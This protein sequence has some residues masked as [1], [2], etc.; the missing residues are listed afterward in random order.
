[1]ADDYYQLLGVSRTATLEE[2]KKAYKSRA[3]ECHPDRPTGS[4]QLF[5][6]VSKAHQVL[7]NTESRRQY[8]R[9]LSNSTEAFASRFSRVATAAQDTAK[10][11]ITDFVDEGLF[12]TLESFLQKKHTPKDIKASVTIS[13]EE[14]YR[15][16]DKAV[17]FSRKEI[18]HVC[19]GR[20]GVAKEDVKV[21]RVCF[22]L[23]HSSESIVDL[24]IGE[25]CK[26]CKGTGRIV[27]K[28]CTQCKGRGEFKYRR[29]HV[30]TIPKDLCLGDEQDHLVMPDEGEYGGDLL[31]DVKLRA[32]KYYE[33]QWPDLHIELPVSF[34]QAILGDNLQLQTLKGNAVFKLPEGTQHGDTIILPGY[35]LRYADS[36]HTRYGDLHVH[37]AVAIP[38]KINKKLKSLLED[39]RRSDS[40]KT[41]KPRK[42]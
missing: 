33:I 26:A 39:Y 22:G 42:K 28:P 31:I 25:D 6:Q 5:K 18:C 2:I 12:E 21:C 3:R 38:K 1:M 17:S 29:E 16:A 8:D 11:V 40:A 14:L 36:K 30:F 15:G 19:N 41:V 37:I 27:V 35:G 20:G 32:H 10:R 23:R 13:I 24:F 4:Q 9:S 34:H 7:S